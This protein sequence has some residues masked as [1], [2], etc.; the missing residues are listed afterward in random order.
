MPKRKQ[1]NNSKKGIDVVLH[2][3]TKMSYISY[4]LMNTRIH[5]GTDA[6]DTLV[7]CL[8]KRSV[9]QPLLVTDK[10]IYANFQNEIVQPVTDRLKAA[11]IPYAIYHGVEPDPYDY[12]VEDGLKVFKENQCDGVIGLGGGSSM[13]TAKCIAIMA[14]LPGEILDY[15]NHAKAI[16]DPNAKDFQLRLVPY[17]ACATTS[18][19]GSEVSKAA[20]IT[21]KANHRKTTVSSPYL[22]S[23]EAILDTNLLVS[24]PRLE[25]SYTAMDALCHAIEAYTCKTTIETPCEVSDATALRA[26]TLITDNVLKVVENPEDLEAR[27]AMQWGALLAGIALNVG[28]GECHAIGSM[29]AKYHGVY[30]GIS[31]GIPL[32]YAMKYNSKYC[33]QRFADIAKAMGKATDGLPVEEAALVAAKA[34]KE[35]LEKL[36]FPKMQDY[37]KDENEIIGWSEECAGNSCCTSNGRMDHKDAI[38]EVCTNCLK[39]EL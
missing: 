12:M 25:T 1:K 22:L 2:R 37:I 20:V 13:D 18:G 30:H 19:T 7:P 26:I 8:Q 29:L 27:K 32:P 9:K 4:D 15:S 34:V 33:P 6:L 39:E 16:H 35:L 21:K 11:G 3:V 23:D 38:I 5:V 24:L 31:V 36:D 28:A 14:K 17:I 10:N